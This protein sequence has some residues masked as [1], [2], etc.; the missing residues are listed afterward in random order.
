[1]TDAKLTILVDDN[2]QDLLTGQATWQLY[3]IEW[4]AQPDGT[5]QGFETNRWEDVLGWF[6][7]RNI[8]IP[9]PE[10]LFVD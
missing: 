7:H 5:C 9:T 8:I 4:D 6:A 2:Q 3:I 1:M 10:V